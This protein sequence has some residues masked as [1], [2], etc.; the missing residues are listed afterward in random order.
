MTVCEG[1]WMFHAI[2]QTEYKL[3]LLA[4]VYMFILMF[5]ITVGMTSVV[6]F[7]SRQHSTESE[8]G[9]T[10]VKTGVGDPGS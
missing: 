4:F 6:Y 5:C 8:F 1:T 2:R 3:A 10:R 9:W 7:Q